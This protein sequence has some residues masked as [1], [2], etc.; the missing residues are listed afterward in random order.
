MTEGPLLSIEDLTV[1]YGAVVAVRGLSLAVPRGRTFAILG[2]NAAGK[3][4]LLKAVLGWHPAA[5]GRI[6]YESQDITSWPPWRRAAAGIAVVPERGRIFTDLTVGE[7]LAMGDYLGGAHPTRDRIEEACRDFP[8][9]TERLR[10]RAGDLSGGQ[11]QMLAI[12][13]ALIARPR[14]LIVDEV[15]SGLAPK[16]VT[17]V[18]DALATLPSRGITLLVAEQNARRALELADQAVVLSRGERV[19]AGPA[20]ELRGERRLVEAYL[21]SQ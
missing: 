16:L 6:R 8:V 2:A 10:H 18:F 9:L 1:R 20:A 11:Q 21:G 13:R 7:N 19:M 12:A 5:G 3:S 15:T 14:L 4:S 17:Q